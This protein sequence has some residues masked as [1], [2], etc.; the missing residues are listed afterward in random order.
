MLWLVTMATRRALVCEDDPSIRA[1]V[2]TILRRDGFEVDL[3]EDG[4]EGLEKLDRGCY[5]VLV[6][7]LMMPRIDGYEVVERLSAR[8]GQLKKVVIMT[9]ATEAIR[10]RFPASVCTLIAKPF[11]IDRFTAIVR[12]CAGRCDRD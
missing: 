1:L 4:Q 2:R 7:D 12:E 3:A 10:N 5:D 9:A 8:P 6:L 11:D